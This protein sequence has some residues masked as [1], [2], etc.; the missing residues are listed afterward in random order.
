M[1][2][3][4]TRSGATARRTPAVLAAAAMVAGAILALPSTAAQAADTLLSQGKTVTAS[5]EE[6]YGTPAVNAVDGNLGSR[7]SSANTDQQ[8]L[9][10]DLGSVATISRVQLNWEG[11]YGKAYQIQT[12]PDGVNWTTVYNTT[13]GTGGNETLNVS[14][15]GRYVRMNGIARATGYG[16]SLWEFQVFGTMGTNPSPSPTPTATPTSTPTTPT[17]GCST[18]NAAQ[19]KAVTASSEENYGTPA[20]NAVDGNTGTR[21]ASA[22]SDS[23]WLQVDLGSS[24]SICQ[25]VLNWEGAYGKGYQIQTSADGNAWTTVYTTTTGAGGNETLNVSGTGR[26]VRLNGTQRGT[27][28]GYSLW[29]FAVRTGSTSTVPPVQGGGDLGPNVKV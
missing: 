2:L 23:Q 13:T 17:G 4:S 21:W 11:A 25:V 5:S 19:G 22:A 24:Q 28:Y 26:Y 29:E 8:W 10:V 18:T 20:V 7:W 1:R 14:G 9:Q 15:T 6:N 12:S 3:T 16:Y 27:G